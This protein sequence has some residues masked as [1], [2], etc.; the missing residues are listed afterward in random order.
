MKKN[1]LHRSE[2]MDNPEKT[3]IINMKHDVAFLDI[4]YKLLVTSPKQ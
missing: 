3:I 2:Y 1:I 4:V